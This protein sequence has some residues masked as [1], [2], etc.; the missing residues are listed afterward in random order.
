MKKA[1]TKLRINHKRVIR[2][3]GAGNIDPQRRSKTVEIVDHP[4]EA[5][6]LDDFRL[7]VVLPQLREI[8]VADEL[9]IG[10]HVFRQFDGGFDRR[11]KIFSGCKIFE[12]FQI[13]IRVAQL[14]C[15]SS[16]RR[17]SIIAFVQLGD[18]DK[19]QFF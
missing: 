13:I 14:L 4:D 15:Q 9:A 5:G 6:Q 2:R 8:F 19:K 12:R 18:F 17:Q 7:A 1:F 3:V 16:M 10:R 11:R